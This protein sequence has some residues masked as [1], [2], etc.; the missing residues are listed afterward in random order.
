MDKSNL[1]KR[2]AEI[3]AGLMIVTTTVAYTSVG[4]RNAGSTAIQSV[5]GKETENRSNDEAGITSYSSEDSY[6]VSSENITLDLNDI[7]GSDEAEMA[8]NSMQ[9]CSDITEDGEGT[10]TV[11][12]AADNSAVQENEHSVTQVEANAEQEQKQK[13]EEPQPVYKYVN[14]SLLNVRSGPS[15]ES[16]KITMLS[17]AT[18]VRCVGGDREWVKIITDDNVEGYVFA[19]YL[20]DTA[21]PVYK[22]VIVNSLNLRKGPSTETEILG[23][24]P[25]G[26]KVQVF[27]ADNNFVRILTGDGKE[28]YVWKE[29]LGDEV[30][31]A[32]RSAS[33][34]QS[35]NADLANKIIEYAKQFLGV[36]Y[37][38]GGS[39]PNGFDCSG[40]TQYVF[41]KFNIKLPRTSYEY[42]GVGTKVSRENIKPGDIL[43]FDVNGS[44]RIGHVGIYIGND[45]FIH[46]SSGKGKVVITTL[47]KYGERLIGIRRVIK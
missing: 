5:T 22:Y 19:E 24:L 47:S 2:C 26:N 8:E 44:N 10:E 3:L 20:S 9:I 32:S 34:G 17:K 21:P 1:L 6:K 39:S 7:S 23:T 12:Q 36:K 25:F 4:I 13:A 37:V 29:Y 30:V 41:K 11:N 28:G 40:F 43:L 46:A 14:V 42:S 35:Y 45:K 16:E 18:R 38:Y 31:L 33:A 27:E 15:T